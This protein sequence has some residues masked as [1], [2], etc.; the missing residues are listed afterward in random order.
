MSTATTT[1]ASVPMLPVVAPVEQVTAEDR[2]YS[3]VWSP[4]TLALAPYA[5]TGSTRL[6]VGLLGG[7]SWSTHRLHSGH[8]KGRV[9]PDALVPPFDYVSDPSF[10]AVAVCALPAGRPLVAARLFGPLESSGG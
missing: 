7:G 4:A 9:A 8:R 2:G 1:R 3:Y 5:G 10:E 6:V